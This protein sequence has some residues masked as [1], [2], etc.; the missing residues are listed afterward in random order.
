MSVFLVAPRLVVQLVKNYSR[1]KVEENYHTGIDESEEKELVQAL[2]YG[3]V[4]SF[5]TLYPSKAQDTGEWIDQ[6]LAVWE[7]QTLERMELVK[8]LAILDCYEYQSCETERWLG[9][10]AWQAVERLRR[11]FIRCLPGYEMV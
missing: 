11:Y 6:C 8:L 4:A 3:N 7:S 1:R 2:A 9:S 10:L 5:N